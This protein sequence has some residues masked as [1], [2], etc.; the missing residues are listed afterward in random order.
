MGRRGG[1][2]QFAKRQKEQKKQKKRQ[3][4]LDRKRDKGPAA[5]ESPS[6]DGV[7]LTETPSAPAPVPAADSP[8]E[9]KPAS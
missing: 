8:P 1:S 3:E 9:I 7:Q 2:F 5:T 4:K 6:D